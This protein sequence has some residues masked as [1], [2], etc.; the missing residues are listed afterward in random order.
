[1]KLLKKVN[2]GLMLTL[3]VLLILVIYLINVES[4]RNSEKPEIEKTCTEYINLMNK[5]AIMPKEAQKL[6]NVS[7]VSSEEKEQVKEKSKKDIENSIGKLNEELKTRMINDELAIEMQ[8]DIVE[9]FVKSSNDEFVSVITSFNKEISKIRK[10]AFDDDQVTVTFSSKADLETKYL[11]NNSEE[12][13]RKSTFNAEEETITLKK[14][15]NTWKVVYADMQY[16][17]YTASSS[18]E[19]KYY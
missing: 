5:Y 14:I 12:V 4:K 16:S 7:E 10:F 19:V 13:T 8:K 3:V 18:M 17:D 9:E 11:E 6:Y 15:D 1:M 2:K